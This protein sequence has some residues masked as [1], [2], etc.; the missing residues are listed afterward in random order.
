MLKPLQ[1]GQGEATTDNEIVRRRC[2]QVGV[3]PKRP[4][5]VSASNAEKKT[6]QQ[7]TDAIKAFLCDSGWP[8][9]ITVDS[10]NGYALFYRLDVSIDDGELLKRCLHALARKFDT[11]HVSIGRS[12]FNPA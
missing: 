3:D 6:A 12:E 2:L 7:A 11:G 4:S 1:P 5:G 10:G 9:P 8:D